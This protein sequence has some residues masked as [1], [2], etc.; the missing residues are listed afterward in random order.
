MYY[1][2]LP[3]W[4]PTRFKTGHSFPNGEEIVTR[5][6]ARDHYMRCYLRGNIDKWY[7]DDFLRELPDRIQRIVGE[8]EEVYDEC[9]KFL[10]K[11][12]DLELE[13]VICYT[14]NDTYVNY[15]E[16][17]VYED[18]IPPSVREIEAEAERERELF[19]GTMIDNIERYQEITDNR[20]F[21]DKESRFL[22]AVKGGDFI[23]YRLWKNAAEKEK[24]E[25]DLK[26]V[27]LLQEAAGG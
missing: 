5:R 23:D 25:R 7:K 27:E 3:W 9:N 6:T 8:N 4:T 2:Q 20:F 24:A 12:W 18:F 10:D 17:P 26:T 19:W 1:S 14:R 11:L 13:S 15:L 22:I 16:L 21:T